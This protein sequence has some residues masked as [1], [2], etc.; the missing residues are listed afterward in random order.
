[1][2]QRPVSTLFLSLVSLFLGV[3]LAAPIARPALAQDA[4]AEPTVRF[5]HVYSGGGPIDIYVDGTV[6]V[7]QL[8]F[9]T[10]TEYAA[11]S[12][13]DHQVQVVATGEAPSAALV[14]TTL[15]FDNGGT[16]NVL[17]G[18]QG[19]KLDARSYEVNVDALDPGQA[20]LRFIQAA[21]DTGNVDIELAALSNADTSGVSGNGTDGLKPI[22]GIGFTDASD[23]Q[24]VIA[25][26]YDIVVREAGTDTELTTLPSIDLASGN[27]YDVVVLGQLSSNN[28]TLLP[29]ITR[30]SQA[31]G[32]IL[33]IGTATDGCVRFVHTSA[34]AGALDI[35]VNGTKV[36]NAIS[37]GTITD[38]TT[39]GTDKQQIQIVPT[40]Q[41]AT[42]AWLDET[43]DPAAG[44]A[45]Q[46]TLLGIAEKDDNNDNDFRLRQD[47]VDLSSVPVGQARARVIHAVT[48][49]GTV[50]ITTTGG[51]TLFDNLSFGDATDY[52]TIAAGTTDLAVS[53]DNNQVIT[54]AKGVEFK[55]GMVYDIV[56][57]GLASDN[58]VQLLIAPTTA[59]VRTGAQGTPLAVSGAQ[60]PTTAPGT[61]AAASVTAVG[62]PAAGQATPTPVGAAPVTP[63]LTP[64]S[65][66]TPTS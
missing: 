12:G 59:E 10:V 38:F 19:D 43:I 50:S 35:Y 4:G 39:I 8:A 24:T 11:F 29:L 33:Q 66:P 6:A 20:R 28:L 53:G 55:E 63:V 64:E 61:V 56:V 48:D 26:T 37:Y 57:S 3:L 23:Y 65:T 41:P 45:Y 40:G 49:G 2:K 1:M 52:T 17:V 15:S 27:V 9:G 54:T 30:I 42:N 44:D 7:Q 62:S 21:P 46:V 31:C 14:D 18:G 32:E 36:V 51:A 22:T 13:G 34:D 25:G 60:T 16:Y 47:R 58:S 5:A